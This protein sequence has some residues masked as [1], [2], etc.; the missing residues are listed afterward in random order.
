GLG[1][2]DTLL[3]LLDGDLGLLD[4]LDDVELRRL[5][6]L[7]GGLEVR[8]RLLVLGDPVPSVEERPREGQADRPVLIELGLVTAELAAAVRTNAGDVGEEVA[9]GLALRGFGGVDREPG[10]T[11]LRPLTQCLAAEL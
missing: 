8:F 9:E 7:L 3:G 4:V 10:L 11:V 6:P 5:H 1:G 2:L